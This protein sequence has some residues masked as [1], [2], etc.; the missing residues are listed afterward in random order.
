MPSSGVSEDSYSEQ[1][2]LEREEKVS[3]DFYSVLTYN[4]LINL[5]KKKKKAINVFTEGW[6]DNGSVAGTKQDGVGVGKT[7]QNFGQSK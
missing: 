7:P 4:Q 6:R 3:E 1:L 2:G 5:K